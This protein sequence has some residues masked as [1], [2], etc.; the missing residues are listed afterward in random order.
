MKLLKKFKGKRIKIFFSK[1][2][3]ETYY[4]I[5]PKEDKPHKKFYFKLVKI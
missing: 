3:S 4:N 2:A 5:K 1:K